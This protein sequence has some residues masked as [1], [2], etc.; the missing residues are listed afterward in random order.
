VYADKHIRGRVGRGASQAPRETPGYDA[1]ITV[2]V[3][4][5]EAIDANCHEDA[6]S[7]RELVDGCSAGLFSQLRL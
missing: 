6:A 5:F 1:F 3:N 7:L 4:L 2:F